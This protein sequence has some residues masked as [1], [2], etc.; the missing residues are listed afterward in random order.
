MRA[1]P[2]ARRVKCD[3]P[4]WLADGQIARQGDDLEAV[5]R[6]ARIHQAREKVVTERLVVAVQFAVGGDGNELW[7]MALAFGIV[8]LRRQRGR[9]EGVGVVG[10]FR[11]ERDGAAQGAIVEEDGDLAPARQPYEIR[12]RRVNWF[13]S[14]PRRQDS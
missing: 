3:G 8:D 2:R 5:R 9:S 11:V 1:A 12:L 7:L 4:R 14:L 6:R 10:G 13:A